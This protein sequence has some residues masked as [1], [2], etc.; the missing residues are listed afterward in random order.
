VYYRQE[1]RQVS[2]IFVVSMGGIHCTQGRYRCGRE[3]AAGEA[4]GCE[5]IHP[6]RRCLVC[7]REQWLC[8]CGHPPVLPPRKPRRATHEDGNCASTQRVVRTA[9][10]ASK[11]SR[12]P[13]RPGVG[14]DVLGSTGSLQ[15]RGILRMP[16][17]QPPSLVQT[18]SFTADVTIFTPI[19]WSPA[20]YRAARKGPW[21]QHAANRRQFTRRIQQTEIE[22]AFVLTNEHRDRIRQRFI[23]E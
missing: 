21:L 7:N 17:V 18:V 12:R 23:D 15:P 3:A 13:P 8:V 4:T 1:Q 2:R 16:G 14:D 5:A 19:D 6:H 22:L 20:S 11:N 9:G 10:A